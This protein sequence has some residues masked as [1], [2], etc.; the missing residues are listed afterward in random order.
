[1]IDVK[2]AEDSYYLIKNIKFKNFASANFVKGAE[3]AGEKITIRHLIWLGYCE[4]KIYSYY[5]GLA[6]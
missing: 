5:Q 6:E 2:N 4:L 3:I 1:M